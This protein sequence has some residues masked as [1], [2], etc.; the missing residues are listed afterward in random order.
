MADVQIASGSSI[1]YYMNTQ[2][3][4]GIVWVTKTLGY[5]FYLDG[6]AAGGDVVY[7]K[8]T[9]GG[10]T[11]GSPVDV[12]TGYSVSCLHVYHDKWTRNVATNLIHVAY[13]DS[14]SDDVKY[15]NLDPDNSDALSAE[16]QVLDGTTSSVYTTTW[17]QK[18]VNVVR[19]EGGYI[20]VLGYIDANQTEKVF[21]VSTDGGANF[22]S[23]AVPAPAGATITPFAILVPGDETDTNDIGCVYWDC[24]NN[25]LVWCVYDQSGDSWSTADISATT[26]AEYTGGIN[27][28][29]AQMQSDGAIYVVAMTQFDNVAADFKVFKITGNAG[30]GYT[31]TEKTDVWTNE[32]EHGFAG[33]FINQQT[34]DIYAVYMG[35]SAAL[36]SVGVKYKK[37][38]DGA[39]TWGAEQSFSADADDDLR[40]VWAG[41]SANG[42]GGRF[43]PAWFNDDLNRLLT[44]YDNGIEIGA[45]APASAACTDCRTGR[46]G[47]LYPGRVSM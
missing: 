27:F 30:A 5:M 10:A 4:G 7:K 25:K 20:Y 9:D 15:R 29:A 34:D 8:T 22:A 41:Q 32:A 21:A 35:G 31:Y 45:E 19:A 40:G 46:L 23:K 1:N 17:T 36:S 37:S 44:N 38:T 18:W 3:A 39:G 14:T 11:W 26:F 28:A 47:W 16:K 6:G 42:T 2:L 24:N 33:I 13:I 12:T 43:Q